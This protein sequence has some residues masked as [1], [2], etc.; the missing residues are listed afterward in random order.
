MNALNDF[1][2]DVVLF[3]AYGREYIMPDEV[4]G[5]WLAGKDFRLGSNGPYCSIRDVDALN[6]KAIWI[7]TGFLVVRVF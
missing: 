3:P 4:R 1:S 2:S 7:D 6:T 5:D